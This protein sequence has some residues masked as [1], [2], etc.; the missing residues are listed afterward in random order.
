MEG[1]CSIP[2][3]VEAERGRQGTGCCSMKLVAKKD[4]RQGLH[5]GVLRVWRNLLQAWGA[6]GWNHRAGSWLRRQHLNGFPGITI[7]EDP[8]VV[9]WSSGVKR[10]QLVVVTHLSL[11]SWA[12]LYSVDQ[13]VQKADYEVRTLIGGKKLPDFVFHSLS[14]LDEMPNC[15]PDF[16]LNLTDVFCHNVAWPAP[17]TSPEPPVP[18]HG[19]TPDVP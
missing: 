12:L 6:E 8:A 15:I 18:V 5:R 10:L 14:V 13:V 7:F 19:R 2:L 9:Q 11:C 16:M 17:L 4:T 3:P 1:N